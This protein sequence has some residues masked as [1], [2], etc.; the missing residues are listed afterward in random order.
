[1][2]KIKTQS[3]Q[4]FTLAEV[5]ITLAVIGIVAALTMPTII[6]KYQKRIVVTRLEKDYALFN[7]MLRNAEAEH[8]FMQNWT[9]NL[10]DNLSSDFFNTYVKPFL[11]IDKVCIPTS[12]ECWADNV[13]SLS[14]LTGYL[15]NDETNRISF[16][17]P[18]GQS[19]YMWIGR[20]AGLSGDSENKSI[21]HIQIKVDIN[22]KSKGENT[23]G[24]DIF[25]MF[26][27]TSNGRMVMTGIQDQQDS[28]S[29]DS[30]MDNST[31]YNCTKEVNS[32]Y[33]GCYCGAVIQLSGWQIPDG[34][35]W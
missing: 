25:G 3:R 9:F 32:V 27:D 4:A 30:L 21:Y 28:F 19:V 17:M 33:A 5:L 34:Y 16:I 1:M 15:R 11:K 20:G 14:G 35:P 26:I 29:A 12:N 7:N 23:L 10:G 24:K 31:H 13:K 6:T 18:D 22:G 2:K 8:G